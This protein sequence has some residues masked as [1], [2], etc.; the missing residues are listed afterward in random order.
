MIAYRET[1]KVNVWIESRVNHNAEI[2]K[3]DR[4][5]MFRLRGQG[6]NQKSNVVCQLAIAGKEAIHCVSE[7]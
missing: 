1:A 3:H 5:E 2:S 7:L 6:G 4:A